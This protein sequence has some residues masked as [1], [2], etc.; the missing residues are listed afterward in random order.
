MGHPRDEVPSVLGPRPSPLLESLLD[1]RPDLWRGRSVPR[2]LPPGVPTGFVDL[3]QEL[4]W[5]GW[6]PGGLVELLIDAPGEGLGL[7]LPALVRLGSVA[8]WLLLVDPP[9][10]PFAPALAAWGLMIERLVVVRGG[11]TAAWAAEQGLRS[12]ACAAVLLW[13]GLQEWA[14]LRRLQLAAETGGG[15]GFLFRG[16]A[17][18]RH[19]SPA[20]LRLRVG[21]GLEPGGAGYRVEVIKQRGGR[22]GALLSLGAPGDPALDS[23]GGAVGWASARRPSLGQPQTSPSR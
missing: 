23:L 5:G 11:E 9:W 19:P 21:A 4:P 17:A 18:A 7:V 22:P 2:S 15:L 3:D 16:S 12:G 6:P 13:S 8:R 14:V 1:R 20:S 10:D